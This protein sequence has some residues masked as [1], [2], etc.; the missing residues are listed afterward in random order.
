LLG[1]RLVRIGSVTDH[2]H[3][4]LFFKLAVRLLIDRAGLGIR[5]LGTATCALSRLAGWVGPR[6]LVLALLTQA[7]AH[8]L[9][10][11]ADA[12]DLLHHLLAFLAALDLVHFLAGFL[13]MLGR[14]FVFAVLQRFFGFLQFVSG[15]LKLFL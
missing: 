10:D 4:L 13:E 8:R 9:F 15:F 14:F 7:L 6:L 1:V 2:I 3:L 5:R 11:L 12:L